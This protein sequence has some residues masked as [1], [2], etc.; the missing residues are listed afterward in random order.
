LSDIVSA[1]MRDGNPLLAKPI[2]TGAVAARPEDE[3]L[4]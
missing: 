2:I 3:H 4:A 1:L